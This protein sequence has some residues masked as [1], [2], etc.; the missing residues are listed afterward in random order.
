MFLELGYDTLW[1]VSADSGA[2]YRFKAS[3]YSAEVRSSIHDDHTI[4]MKV[5]KQFYGLK[6]RRVSACYNTAVLTTTG[7]TF[8]VGPL[9]DH[10]PAPSMVLWQRDDDKV[11]EISLGF[12]MLMLVT[13]H[14]RIYRLYLSEFWAHPTLI[15]DDPK[16]PIKSVRFSGHRI[17]TALSRHG[18]LFLWQEVPP[19][20]TNRLDLRYPP[21][22]LES[23]TTPCLVAVPWKIESADYHD[24]CLAVASERRFSYNAIFADFLNRAALN[25]V[26]SSNTLS[27][28][29]RMIIDEPVNYMGSNDRFRPT[30]KD[31][32]L[33]NLRAYGTSEYG[34]GGSNLYLGG[35]STPTSDSRSMSSPRP[36]DL[37]S[38]LPE[39]YLLTSSLGS[40]GYGAPSRST[41][42]YG[43]GKSNRAVLARSLRLSVSR[44]IKAP[45]SLYHS[46]KST[47]SD[48]AQS[49]DTDEGS[50]GESATLSPMKD[51]F[52][53]TPEQFSED[54]SLMYSFN[55]RLL[56]IYDMPASN[57]DEELTKTMAFC[58][59]YEDFLERALEVVKVIIEE[60]ALEDEQKTYSS[61]P[62]AGGVAGGEKYLIDGNIFVK[63]CV[64]NNS[65]YGGNEWASKIANLE[66]HGSDAYAWCLPLLPRGHKLRVP[67]VAMI[68]YGGFRALVS[69]AC[70]ISKRTI[71]YGSND[72][73]TTVHNDDAEAER[74]MQQC[75][76]ILNLAP[77]QVKNGNGKL[78]SSAVDVEVHR[79]DDGFLYILDTARVFPPVAPGASKSIVLGH[80]LSEEL[81]ASREL[82]EAQSRSLRKDLHSVPLSEGQLF[83][84]RT[85][86]AVEDNISALRFEIIERERARLEVER[87]EMGL[88]DD[89]PLSSAPRIATILSNLNGPL[90]H[91][92]SEP[93]ETDPYSGFPRVSDPGVGDFEQAPEDREGYI[94]HVATALLGRLVLGEAWFLANEMG[95]RLW[96]QFRPEFVMGY[97][98]PLSS[99][100]LSAFAVSGLQHDEAVRK[101]TDYLNH[102]Y[103]VLVQEQ[104]ASTS[105]YLNAQFVHRTKRVDHKGKEA[106]NLTQLMPLVYSPETLIRFMHSIGLNIR[107]L[108]EVRAVLKIRAHHDICL[109]EMVS[110]VCTSFVKRRLRAAH[111]LFATVQQYLSRKPSSINNNAGK[112]TSSNANA[113][114]S[115]AA[116]SSAPSSESTKDSRQRNATGDLADWDKLDEEDIAQLSHMT[117]DEI[118]SMLAIQA[119]TT[120]FSHSATSSFFWSQVIKVQLM[121]KFG[122]HCLFANEAPKTHDLRDHVHFAPLFQTV[123]RRSGVVWDVESQREL[124]LAQW[125]C[126]PFE[127]TA[128]KIV[129]Y[130][131]SSKG[132]KQSSISAAKMDLKAQFFPTTVDKPKELPES[133]DHLPN[134]S[135]DPVYKHFYHDQRSYRDYPPKPSD[136]PLFTSTSSKSSQDG[137]STDAKAE[138]LDGEPDGLDLYHRNIIG[139]YEKWCDKLTTSGFEVSA[140]DQ[141][142]LMIAKI[143]PILDSKCPDGE[144][145]LKHVDSVLMEIPRIIEDKKVS[146]INCELMANIYYAKGQYHH[147]KSELN[148]AELCYLAAVNV[149]IVPSFSE[150]TIDPHSSE[151]ASIPYLKA[152]HDGGPERH[153]PTWS[154]SNRRAVPH[155]LSLMIIDKLITIHLERAGSVAYAYPYWALFRTTW[156]ICPFLG[157]AA[158]KMRL[159]GG[160]SVPLA[161]GHP[162]AWSH[163]WGSEVYSAEVQ[164]SWIAHI[165]EGVLPLESPEIQYW[166]SQAFDLES[167]CSYDFSTHWLLSGREL[168][169]MSTFSALGTVASPSP[170][171]SIP[172]VLKPNKQESSVE[173]ID[174]SV[175]S[176]SAPIPSSSAVPSSSGPSPS[177]SAPSPSSPYVPS[178]FDRS[179]YI[180]DSTLPTLN[181]LFPQL[182]RFIAAPTTYASFVSAPVFKPV[183][184]LSSFKSYVTVSSIAWEDAWAWFDRS[185]GNKTMLTDFVRESGSSEL[186]PV[187]FDHVPLS[188]RWIPKHGSKGTLGLKTLLAVFRQRFGSENLTLG[189]F[190]TVETGASH[191]GNEQH[192][193]LKSWLTRVKRVRQSL[194]DAVPEKFVTDIFQA[195]AHDVSN[196]RNPELREAV[197]EADRLFEDELKMHHLVDTEDLPINED[198]KPSARDAKK[199]K[200]QADWHGVVAQYYAAPSESGHDTFNEIKLIS[201]SRLGMLPVATSQYLDPDRPK[202]LRYVALLS[203]RPEMMRLAAMPAWFD[204]RGVRS[205]EIFYYPEMSSVFRS[206]MISAPF[207]CITRDGDVTYSADFGGN[208][209]TEADWKSLR[210][211]DLAGERITTLAISPPEAMVN[212]ISRPSDPKK[213]QSTLMSIYY[214]NA[215]NGAMLLNSGEEDGKATEEQIRLHQLAH[216]GTV[217]CVTQSGRLFVWGSNKR[218]LL[219]FGSDASDSSPHPRVVAS[220]FH[221]HIIDVQLGPGHIVTLSKD[222]R[223]NFWGSI[224]PSHPHPEYFEREAQIRYS[225]TH[226]DRPR[227]MEK[228][229]PSLYNTFAQTAVA[230]ATPSFGV[231][232]ISQ[233]GIPYYFG[234]LGP[235]YVTPDFERVMVP[236]RV[237]DVAAGQWHSVYLSEGGNVYVWGF[238]H[239]SQC[240]TPLPASFIDGT[241]RCLKAL[242]F[243]YYR[244]G[245]RSKPRFIQIAAAGLYSA[246]LTSDGD[247]WLWG[248][249]KYGS[250][251]H[252]PVPADIKRISF[253]HDYQL[254]LIAE[255]LPEL[256]PRRLPIM[257]T[258]EFN[259]LVSNF[260]AIVNQRIQD[261]LSKTE[262]LNAQQR[263]EAEAMERSRRELEA[264]WND[265]LN[266]A[267]PKDPEP[268]PELTTQASSEPISAATT[269]SSSTPSSSQ[270]S[271]PSDLRIK[272]VSTPSSGHPSL[273]HHPDEPLRTGWHQTKIAGAS[274]DLTMARAPLGSS[275]EVASLALT[276]SDGGALVSLFQ[277]M[278][279]SVMEP[280]LER[281]NRLEA[282]MKQM[283]G[284]VKS[285]EVVT[286]RTP[287]DR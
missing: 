155:P 252:I 265:R 224:I 5:E 192:D 235:H 66:L 237:V 91:R 234:L 167:T 146:H 125:S 72:A 200:V 10:L 62:S 187:W 244:E 26:R 60:L 147:L 78:M 105:P 161:F 140:L 275:N 74:C 166:L 276:R 246:A 53:F 174:T 197:L 254:L 269:T 58:K 96:H 6:I 266:A 143:R 267:K 18:Q 198:E 106:T 271:Q 121:L 118:R 203:S 9:F 46:N 159:F 158:A 193:M 251:Y 65:L 209:P 54:E 150:D 40:T 154:Y 184:V 263:L 32:Q 15:F 44:P 218:G 94:N 264:E 89:V 120:I 279:T 219:G 212:P 134:W 199:K 139:F 210:A 138:K 84:R 116:S 145:D 110:R 128:D 39:S 57:S 177:T 206:S 55:T 123:S 3:D 194:R 259:A 240:G 256:Q 207:V 163:T 1:A 113:A 133:N 284:K 230:I 216:S 189:R 204:E 34:S 253:S 24:S 227:P 182:L 129:A 152:F 93:D 101:A 217:A 183:S 25:I 16:S 97:S 250:P 178:A 144:A 90:N 81:I 196:L 42:V 80:S 100:A 27:S 33:Y 47:N 130:A 51:S 176:S 68:D 191:D 141:I 255:D 37:I 70:P 241:T 214:R 229:L 172:E 272:S 76:F 38:G 119:F 21:S 135:Y 195:I 45:N 49:D 181:P 103:M 277:G 115:S 248:G 282:R 169:G 188:H 231:S 208:E 83:F 75:S 98:T 95:Q 261:E 211:F 122:S 220:L 19:P 185:R 226:P 111:A 232:A 274:L 131:L 127:L 257:P 149:L 186:R 233:F 104:L 180:H 153:L 268:L 50:A 223:L 148:E 20:G 238:N 43:R 23:R 56:D 28:N 79:G 64:D 151:N 107:H 202:P 12:N 41:Y 114:S 285:L 8:L 67:I 22:A 11:V 280:V 48:S 112:T 205:M 137:T 260:E 31:Y 124:E 228:E 102:A 162:F 71:V 221:Q 69:I 88:D 13:S 160:H 222:G 73:A 170:S 201:Y 171:A 87:S 132:S 236:E 247:V 243:D 239:D 85:K 108:G 82:S 2:L 14:G 136:D 281:L 35:T 29:P 215:T 273:A 278:L 270:A 156:N 165:R 52:G 92:E 30:N 213:H 99:D 86:A 173:E 117:L 258:D 157:D 175:A 242:E 249:M 17:F 36:Y 63:L 168:T 126:L 77:H 190:I 179:K 61:L 287:S 262:S 7:S 164:H 4:P 225:Q 283:E 286:S 142:R 245:A 109:M 59:L